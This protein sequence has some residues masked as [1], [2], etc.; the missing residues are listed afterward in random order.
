MTTLGEIELYGP[1]A[2]L[3]ARE[4][5]RLVIDRIT[6]DDV[7]SA[8]IA[9]AVSDVC[10]RL[11]LE[12]DHPRL[13]LEL[14]EDHSGG[15]NLVL[16]FRGWSDPKRDGV[17][18]RVFESVSADPSG[19]GIRAIKKLSSRSVDERIISA[20]RKVVQ[21]K[22]R[23]QLMLE[24]QAQNLE[25]ERHR[26]QL[27]ET[28]R[29]RTQELEEAMLVADD[30]NKAKSAFLANMSHELRTPMNAIIGY[31]EMLSED[32]EEE[33]LEDMLDDL[34]KIT[35]AGK[36]LLSLIN[37]VLDLSKIEAGKMDLFLEDFSIKE[38]AEDVANTAVSLVEKNSNELALDVQ[39]DLENLH[40][41]VTKIRQILFNLISNAAKFT[42][43]GKITLAAKSDTLGNVPAVRLA[44]TD[45]GIGIPEDKLEHI[46]SEFSQAD[47][48]T[49]RDY[50][51]TGLGLTLT[52]RFCELMGGNIRVE[53]TLGQG[54]SFIVTLPKQ[55]EKQHLGL[56]KEAV[57][58]G[59][60]SEESSPDSEA[61]MTEAE[62]TEAEQFEG[63]VAPNKV[64]VIEDEATAR[65]LLKK[66]LE[67]EGCSVILAKTGAE[68][69][70]LAAQHKPALITLDVMM[71]G[72]DGWT[73]L[74]RLKADN[75]LKDIPVAMISMVGDKAMSYQLGA[76][77]SLQK[78]VDRAKL[79]ALVKKYASDEIKT[80]LVV[81]DDPAARATISRALQGENWEIEDAENGKIALE[82]TEKRKF[83]L[84]LLDLMMPVM[85]GFEFLERLRSSDHPS[86]ESPVI[87]VTAMELNDDER[88]RLHRNVQDV[89]SKIGENIDGSLS[90]ILSL[91]R[92]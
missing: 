85:D 79:S 33:G 38:V 90:E 36:H 48:S 7:S 41:D 25:L 1:H 39:Q 18:N 49:T 54:S 11:Y 26:N 22:G 87:I 75:S 27:E 21:A 55:A 64:L 70:K 80:A 66:R 65:E 68:G 44:V 32:A 67:V 57:V 51:G 42:K 89:V 72:M 17:L 77:E 46:F 71:P 2:Y 24:I 28:V 63:H 30:A 10:R 50:G 35:A 14:L 62:M 91:L 73:V 6:G 53:S 12:G 60:A 40:G 52:K 9:A 37:D 61:E 59:P 76:V 82:K 88:Q 58:G 3:E 69:L 5:L 4:K 81:E 34:K 86:A 78:P 92:K 45:T 13:S 74:S 15:L 20:S 56:E 8:R 23:D 29:Q 83:S 43:E 47:E 84:I 19:D 16:S 31:S